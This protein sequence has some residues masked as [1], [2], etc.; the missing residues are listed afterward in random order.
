MKIG[1]KMNIS[2]TTLDI[3]SNFSGINQSVKFSGNTIKTIAGDVSQYSVQAVAVA[4]IEEDFENQVAIYDLSSFLSLLKI[5]CDENVTAEFG[6]NSVV[7]SSSD[8][9][10]TFKYCNPDII[11]DV[12]DI[13]IKDDD[14]LLS[15][16]LDQKVLNE[17]KRVSAALKFDGFYLKSAKGKLEIRL[18][19]VRSIT[20]TPEHVIKL[21]IKVDTDFDIYFEMK[22]LFVLPGNYT[23]TVTENML[24]FTSKEMDLKYFI[25][26]SNEPV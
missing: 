21:P 19:D 26:T 23:V 5:Y 24:A 1:R 11:Q 16:E 18:Y 4:K 2:K 22:N 20:S 25:V 9:S 7:L 15:F 10:T 3:L 17:I 8:R 13:K 6:K 12:P 14:V